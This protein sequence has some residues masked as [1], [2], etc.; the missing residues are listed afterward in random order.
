[1]SYSTCSARNCTAGRALPQCVSS[2]VSAAVFFV[3]KQ[4]W[5]LSFIANFVAS[6][7]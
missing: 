3:E 5:I 4:N 2:F 1:M 6:R 7:Q